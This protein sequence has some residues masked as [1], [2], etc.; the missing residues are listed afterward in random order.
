MLSP[1]CPLSTVHCPPVLFLS[2]PL[3]P[4]WSGPPPPLLFVILLLFYTPSL[5]P[6]E[7]ATR[8]HTRQHNGT[9]ARPYDHTTDHT[10]IR[11]HSHTRLNHNTSTQHDRHDRHNRH[12]SQAYSDSTQT[13]ICAPPSCWVF[14]YTPRYLDIWVRSSDTSA[15]EE[16]IY[17][18]LRSP[19][20]TRRTYLILP[21]GQ[22]GD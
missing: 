2:L 22:L 13:P 10:T 8:Q 12:N 18:H 20:S 5:A 16:L 7:V 1:P 11:P 21:G 19:S 9:T 3:V 14:E 6:L 17:T 15:H 4:L